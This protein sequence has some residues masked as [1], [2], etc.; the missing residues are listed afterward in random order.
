MLLFMDNTALEPEAAQARNV[1]H[2]GKQNLMPRSPA[3]CSHSARYRA[4]YVFHFSFFLAAT[5]ALAKGAAAVDLRKVMG[6]RVVD[7][8]RKLCR[9]VPKVLVM[10]NLEQTPAEARHMV[11]LHFR[12]NSHI[13]D[14]R[15]MEMFLARAEME[16]EETINQWKQKGHLM[17][18]LQPEASA[19]DPW[20]DEEEFFRRRVP[21]LAL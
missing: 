2:G 9:S 3:A 5:M 15:I 4:N 11:L 13:T 7:M 18:I 8:Y 12:K 6:K 10:Y 20:Y 21:V 14:P 1:G 16:Y 17:A 19:P